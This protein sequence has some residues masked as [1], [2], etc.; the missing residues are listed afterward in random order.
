VRMCRLAS[1]SLHG[2]GAVTSADED[3]WDDLCFWCYVT[4]FSRA[5]DWDM[6]CLGSGPDRGSRYARCVA[7][8]LEG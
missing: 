1:L 2:M 8:L 7:T 5:S 4:L 3:A 6:R